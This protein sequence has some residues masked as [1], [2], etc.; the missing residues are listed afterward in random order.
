MH[1]CHCIAQIAHTEVPRSEIACNT[2]ETTPK[3]HIFTLFTVLL[4]FKVFDEFLCLTDSDIQSVLFGVALLLCNVN[5][6]TN[7]QS[8][9]RGQFGVVELRCL[10]VYLVGSFV[11]LCL[12][13]CKFQ[14]CTTQLPTD[15]HISRLSV[16]ET[17]HIGKSLACVSV[18]K[19]GDIGFLE[20]TALWVEHHTSLGSLSTAQRSVVVVLTHCCHTFVEIVHRL[21]CTAFHL[22]DTCT[23]TYF[24]L[25]CKR[26]FA[27]RGGRCF[28]FGNSRCCRRLFVLL[29]LVTLLLRHKRPVISRPNTILFPITLHNG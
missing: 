24:I 27:C 3:A 14:S 23:E 13:F 2:T 12:Q 10:I 20:L 5:I 21:L 17:F 25:F 4:L 22:L 9:K 26:C 29:R 28:H 19:R 1:H 15:G 8:A 7:K 6:S 11:T 18:A 16:S